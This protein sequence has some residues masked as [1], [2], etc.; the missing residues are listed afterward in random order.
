MT[1]NNN[2]PPFV[3]YLLDPSVYPYEVA[4]VDLV[5]THISYVVLA[6]DFVY[7]FKKPVDFGFLDPQT[8]QAINRLAQ[9][10]EKAQTVYARTSCRMAIS[11]DAAHQLAH[12]LN[13]L[14]QSVRN[15]NV[16]TRQ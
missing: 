8:I 13:Q 5:Q 1:S 15:A 10:G 4:Q 14:L 7:K 12:Q 9:S 3:Q 11:L 16:P 2:L 6:G